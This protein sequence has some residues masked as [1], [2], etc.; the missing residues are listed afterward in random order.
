MGE[1]LVFWRIGKPL[2]EIGQAFGMNILTSG[3]RNEARRIRD[4]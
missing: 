3:S 2:A 1:L 4:K